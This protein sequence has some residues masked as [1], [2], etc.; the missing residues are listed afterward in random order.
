MVYCEQ[1]VDFV[2]HPLKRAMA[3]DGSM[4]AREYYERLRAFNIAN[5]Y[6][7][8]NN[9]LPWPEYVPENVTIMDYQNQNVI[10]HF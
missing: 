4:N 8:D 1:H 7:E 3:Y 9:N 6:L 2:P 10:E 5:G